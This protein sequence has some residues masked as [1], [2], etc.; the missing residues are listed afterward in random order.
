VRICIHKHRPIK[1]SEL[2]HRAR[3]GVESKKKKKGILF[4]FKSEICVVRIP[5]DERKRMEKS[6]NLRNNSKNFLK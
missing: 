3:K 4:F 6:N 5:E 1:I 2:N